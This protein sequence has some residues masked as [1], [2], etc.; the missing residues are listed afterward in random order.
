LPAA[1]DECGAPFSIEHTLDCH[2]GG[3]VG[4]RHN[5]VRDAFGDLASLVWSL[6]LKKP[7]VCDGSAGN[8][9]TLIVDLCVRGVWQP[10]TEALFDIIVVDTDAQ[11]YSACTPL[12][13][14]C[15]AKAEKKRKYLQACHDRHATFTPLCVSVDG[16]L[17]P[18]TEFF[19]KRLSDFL[20]PSG[21]VLM[22][23]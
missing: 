23:L 10:L 12:V 9:D 8:S 19:V 21:R 3:L 6:V 11:S 4:C 1:C 2:Y 14:L 15:L 17:G 20:L 7:V 16:V 18:E 13:V 5:E 22:E